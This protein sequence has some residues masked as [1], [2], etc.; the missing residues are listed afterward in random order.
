[1]SKWIVHTKGGYTTDYF[2][3]CVLL[4]DNKHGKQS[5]GWYGEDKIYISD[6]G[7][8]CHH[9]IASK[10]IWDGLVELAH[11]VADKM[12]EETKLRGKNGNL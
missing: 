12:N 8:P 1:M 9:K 5:Y 3:I 11:K 4:S 6:S 10:M 2:E 7:G